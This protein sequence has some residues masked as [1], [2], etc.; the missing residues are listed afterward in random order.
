[1]NVAK[2]PGAPN[3]QAGTLTEALL[4]VEPQDLLSLNWVPELRRDVQVGDGVNLPQPRQLGWRLASKPQ[5]EAPKPI[6]RA[7][8]E[9]FKQI[10]VLT[11]DVHG[12]ARDYE[13]SRLL[14]RE[15]APSC[16]ESIVPVV[17]IQ[18]PN[19]AQ[20]LLAQV[21]ICGRQQEVKDITLLVGAT[22]PRKL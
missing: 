8:Q 13:R 22:Y 19:A 20:G 3:D 4:P 6:T 2:L 21:A 15:S 17:P 7:G 5:V 16:Y 12:G 9:L 10:E 18:V 14:V 11:E 1:L